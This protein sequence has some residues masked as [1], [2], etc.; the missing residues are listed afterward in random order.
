MTGAMPWRVA[1]G[2]ELRALLPMWAT[3]MIALA[4]TSVVRRVSTTNLTWPT[5]VLGALTLGALSIGHE[6]L[7][8]TLTS[9]LALPVSRTRLIAAKVAVLVSLLLPL[10]AL[11][12]M[13]LSS[14]FHRFEAYELLVIL[15]LAFAVLVAPWM[16]MLARGPLGGVVFTIAAAVGIAA[17]NSLWDRIIGEALGGGWRLTP[18]PFAV[19]IIA[20]AVLGWR[21]IARLEALDGNRD[22]RLPAWSRSDI[23]APTAVRRRPISALVTKELHLQ[24]TTTLVA[25]LSIAVIGLLAWSEHHRYSFSQGLTYP[26]SILHLIVIPILAGAVASAE[27]RGLGVLSWQVLQPI[28]LWKQWAIKVAVAI[29]LALALGVG[30]PLLIW[31]LDPAADLA[32]GSGRITSL[33]FLTPAAGLTL[34]LVIAGVYV[35][36]LFSSGLR[37]ALVT[38]PVAAGLAFLGLAIVPSTPAVGRQWLTAA[39]L[40]LVEKLHSGRFSAAEADRARLIIPSTTVVAA[41]IVA[42]VFILLGL[43][44]H[45][46]PLQSTRRIVRQA[47]AIVVLWMASLVA[48]DAASAWYFTGL[49]EYP[50]RA[51]RQ[52]L[53]TSQ[54]RRVRW[55]SALKGIVAGFK[56]RVGVCAADDQVSA[57]CIDGLH[58]FP[59]QSVMK[60]PLAIAVLDEVDNGK[61]RLDERILVRKQDLSVYVQ[62]M[63]KLVGPNGFET[64][65]DDLMR[66]ALVDSDNAAADILIARLGG[67]PAVQ[68]ALRRKGISN[69]RVDRDE[70]HLQ[71]EINGLEWRAEYLDPAAF[72]RAVDAV[73]PDKRDAAFQAYLHD[74]R[75]TST[76]IAMMRLLG[77]LRNFDLLSPSSR[78]HLL[79]LLEQTTPGSDRLKAGLPEGWTIGHKTGTSGSWRGVTAATN[80]VGIITSPDHAVIFVAVFIADSAA[81]DADRAGLMAKISRALIETYK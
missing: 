28:A 60:L 12:A 78:D 19:F 44:N 64:T 35:S 34:G 69:I 40:P 27:E 41:I 45:R 80:D 33:S 15:P 54:A 74:E 18:N 1:I 81:S 11:M 56:G 49:R 20:S 25:T 13:L 21:A 65:I 38:V 62:P 23:D 17:T 6:Y 32:F 42:A 36:S 3:A 66:R 8:A 22:L 77:L 9:F 75:D 57:A 29:G 31:W 63:A 37:A 10:A 51:E 76:P 7:S 30:G 39:L 68:A 79:E 71:T 61:L 59:M 26:S 70:K 48:V 73:P 53:A 24:Q 5:F 4:L 67:P 46:T 14:E 55:Q 2:K 50:T 58:P 52:A 16:T 72:D 47:V 43:A